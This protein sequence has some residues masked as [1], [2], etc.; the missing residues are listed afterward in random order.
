MGCCESKD[1]EQDE[2][3]KKEPLLVGKAMDRGEDASTDRIKT[4][5]KEA[6]KRVDGGKTKANTALNEPKAAPEKEQKRKGSEVFFLCLL[7]A[8]SRLILFRLNDPFD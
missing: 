3:D 7:A 8:C 4:K 6:N 1:E 5:A 2:V